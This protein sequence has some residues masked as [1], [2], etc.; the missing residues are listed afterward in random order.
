MDNKSQQRLEALFDEA[1]NRVAGTERQAFLD[2]A[3]GGDVNLRSRVDVL[4]A[5]H[6]AADGFL[7][8]PAVT[9]SR[10][11]PGT[12]I[13][14]YKLLQEIGEGGMGVVYMAEQEEPV[15]R[16]V[17][18]KVIKLGMDTKQ[19][20]ARFE[21]ERQALAL[22][23]H[24]NI[25]R[26][27]D[28]GATDEG[29]PYFVMEL[30]RGVPIDKYCDTHKLA[31]EERL[32][33]FVDVCRAVQHA[34][35]KGIIHRDLKPTNVMV[36]S[37]DGVPI[38]KIID[39][40]VAKA[41]NQKLTERTLF[42]EF[43]QIIGTPEYMSPEQAEM[44]GT[45]VD[46]RSDIYSLGVLLYQL[47]TG[48]TPVDPKE[49]RTAAYEEM[50]R[51][52][53]E[54]EAQAP[55]TRISKLGAGGASI[56]KHR[57]SDA[58]AL[59]RYFKGD[60]DWI[61]MKAIEKD[62]TR[63]YETASDFAKDIERHLGS[64]P[65]EAGPPGALYRLR[66]FVHRNQ[67]QVMA[68]LVLMIVLGLGLAGTTVGFLQ[69][70]DEASR[71][72][73]ISDSLQDVLAMSDPAS[74]ASQQ[75]IE[76][77][78]A[79]V[80][81]LFGKEHATYA[82]VLDTLS[83]R[84]LESGNFEVAEEL[85]RESLSVWRSIHSENH[86][87]VGVA[88]SRLGILLRAQ[89]DDAQAEATL[90]NSLAILDATSET[91]SLAGMKARLELADLLGNRGEYT[92]ADELLGQALV[93][94][95]ASPSPAH[96]KIIA[97][98]EK[99]S[100]LQLSQ[101]SADARETV[102]E[103]YEEIHAFYPDDSPLLGIAAFGYGRQLFQHD[104]P[105]L[106][107]PY[108]RE[109]IARLETNPGTARFYLLLA[110]DALFQI[111]RRREDPAS[112]LETDDLLRDLI[113]SGRSIWG[114]NTLSDTLMYYSSRLNTRKRWADGIDAMLEAHQ[115]LLDAGRTDDERENVRD[116]LTFLAF[117]IGFAADQTPELYARAR[118]AIDIAIR[119]EPDH[120]AMLAVLGVVQY[121]QGEL[122]LAVQNLTRAKPLH[123]YRGGLARKIAPADHAFR[124]MALARTGDLETAQVEL[125]QLRILAPTDEDDETPLI[126]RE[127]EAVLESTR[128]TQ[129]HR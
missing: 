105:D 22:M 20:I 67:A 9:S 115:V 82:A 35:Q 2:G 59:S 118:R 106:A 42:T 21:A 6:D 119:A 37:H 113:E 50:T 96:F 73:Q 92:E 15:R 125:D 1:R 75:G 128:S 70:R 32:K 87:N 64:H 45:D 23:D 5:A 41:T 112:E 121:R 123:E 55:S 89:G 117:Q 72:N 129:D 4:L 12:A 25:A 3:C 78:L 84:L 61:V 49:L 68:G 122:E 104:Q 34:H 66:K 36:T 60:L 40:G 63:R 46:T 80:K 74:S 31:T 11:A 33:L 77:V 124:A 65:V 58:L 18:L 83:G 109:A 19:V 48:T 69:A 10:E 51:M 91:P 97:T 114:A 98:L 26:V 127:V 47:L 56:A 95:R 111:V 120:S 28:A 103:I 38:P 13:G 94:L 27:L 39:F 14:P 52:I 79:T 53:R 85:T 30:V 108:L 110:Q 71:S 8:V 100:L 7:A 43:H 107:E 54:D 24:A 29:R 86:P 126:I 17:A 102:R 62:R 76:E 90:R 88:L 81:E 16:K 57:N 44:S 116:N 101:P 93:I 99:R